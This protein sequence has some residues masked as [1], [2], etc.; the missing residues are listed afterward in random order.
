MILPRASSRVAEDLPAAVVTGIRGCKRFRN[1]RCVGEYGHS[2]ALPR[3]LRHDAVAA[4][5]ALLHHMEGVW[6]RAQEQGA[7]LLITNGELYTD[8]AQHAPS[9]VAGETRLWKCRAGPVTMPPCLP[10]WEFPPQ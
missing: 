6:N 8:A 2:G 10:S 9:K 4:T 1:A 5:V 3:S 7:D